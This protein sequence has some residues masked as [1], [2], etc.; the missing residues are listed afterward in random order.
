MAGTLGASGFVINR[1]DIGLE[2]YRNMTKYFT[3]LVSRSPKFI[4]PDKESPDPGKGYTK[5]FLFKCLQSGAAA[6]SG[7]KKF[8]DMIEHP[9]NYTVYEIGSTLRNRAPQ[10]YEIDSLRERIPKAPDIASI[11]AAE[12]DVYYA[13][14]SA[15]SESGNRYRMN[16]SLNLDHT[17]AND[18]AVEAGYKDVQDLFYHLFDENSAERKVF[19]LVEDYSEYNKR[20]DIYSK[21]HI[22]PDADFHKFLEERTYKDVSKG[23]GAVS[24]GRRGY[25][26][27]EGK[28]RR[29]QDP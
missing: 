14:G 15:V 21:D 6:E 23:T 8:L 18:R 19:D 27:C 16:S 25:Q 1:S 28:A 22:D 7:D 5:D 11:K 29:R 3:E 24:C 13:I 20:Q 10:N 2:G 4:V 17:T 9:E 12:R 26:L